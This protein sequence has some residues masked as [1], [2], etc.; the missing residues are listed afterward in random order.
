MA[1]AVRFPW[2]IDLILPG[3][4][5]TRFRFTL[6]FL[7]TNREFGDEMAHAVDL[8]LTP[9]DDAARTLNGLLTVQRI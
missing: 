8:L 4:S 6:A 9:S 7:Q 5:S 2:R 1:S 3:N